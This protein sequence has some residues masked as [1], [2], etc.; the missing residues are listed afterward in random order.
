MIR[1]IINIA[2]GIYILA[3][4]W[5]I[6]L[7]EN[8]ITIR[9]ISS[10]IGIYQYAFNARGGVVYVSKGEWIILS[11]DWWI[12]IAILIVVGLLRAAWNAW[13]PEKV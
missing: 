9:D 7:F 11:N 1:K 4:G 10:P 12:F 5:L 3:G 6:F 8:K 2:V 13:N